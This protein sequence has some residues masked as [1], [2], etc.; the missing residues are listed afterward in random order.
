[1][2]WEQVVGVFSLRTEEAGVTLSIAEEKMGSVFS[3][4]C[5]LGTDGDRVM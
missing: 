4:F 2:A 1:M 5:S 3:E